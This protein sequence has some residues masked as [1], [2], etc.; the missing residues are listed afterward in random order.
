[1]VGLVNIPSSVESVGYIVVSG[2]CSES[3]MIMLAFHGLCVPQYLTWDDLG[4][5]HR[6]CEIVVYAITGG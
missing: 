1:M 3:G 5:L 2:R 4:D 6:L